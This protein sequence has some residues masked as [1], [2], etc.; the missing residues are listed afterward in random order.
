MRW[1]SAG[2]LTVINTLIFR[3]SLPLLAIPFAIWMAQDGVGFFNIIDA[4][5][6]LAVL[7]SF[8]LLDLSRWFQ[9]WLLHWVPL[10][11]LLHRTHHADHDYDFTTGL[12]FHPGETLFTAGAHLYHSVRLETHVGDS[13]RGETLNLCGEQD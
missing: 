12:R 1:V 3:F 11:W 9:H 8:W 6:W 2:C 13:Q 7:L 4:P 10:L 5:L